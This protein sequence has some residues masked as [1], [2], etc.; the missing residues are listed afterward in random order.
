[1]GGSST[2]KGPGP[3]HGAGV[4]PH[5]GRGWL[6]RSDF[7]LTAA[8]RERKRSSSLLQ[9]LAKMRKNG[10]RESATSFVGW[11]WA[12]PDFS[13][14]TSL[15]DGLGR[16]ARALSREMIL[17][18]AWRPVRDRLPW[19]Q[20]VLRCEDCQVRT[21]PSLRTLRWRRGRWLRRRRVPAPSAG[22]HSSAQPMQ[23]DYGAPAHVVC[24]E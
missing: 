21:G 24:A 23:H 7:W 6:E 14:R 2:E 12:N 15:R 17:G 5:C 18:Q 4:Q 3:A 13:S 19:A 16:C 20:Y 9:L 8:L 10:W 1:M 11:P 22:R